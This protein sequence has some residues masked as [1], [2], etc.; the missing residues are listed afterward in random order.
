MQQRSCGKLRY[1]SVSICE[2]YRGW[3]LLRSNFRRFQVYGQRCSGTNAL[4][5]LLERNLDRLCFTE[6]FGFKH[7]LVPDDVEIPADV[8]VI[9]IARDADQWLRSLH[10]RPWHAV[11]ELK[12]L[13][14]S[15]FIRAEWRTRWDEDFWGVDADDPRF[16]KPIEHELCPRTGSPFAN[17]IAMRTAKLSNWISVASR[18]EGHLFVSHADLVSRPDAIVEQVADASRTRAKTPFRPVASYKGQNGRVFQ[19]SRYRELEQA[20]AEHVKRYLDPEIENL[21]RATA[22]GQDTL[23]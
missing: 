11:P 12:R 17:P 7:W 20:D 18:A 9:V 21:F 5:K 19:P 16:G 1:T 13:D 14:F 6:D 22:T 10:A 4:I 23:A 15:D 8:F 2:L 3:F